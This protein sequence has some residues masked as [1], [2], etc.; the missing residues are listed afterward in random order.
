MNEHH[1]EY[2]FATFLGTTTAP[3]W[4]T[5][6]KKVT[7]AVA[8]LWNL[9]QAI[10]FEDGTEEAF[11][12]ALIDTT[13]RFKI[14]KSMLYFLLGIASTNPHDPFGAVRAYLNKSDPQLSL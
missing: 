13:I 6:K 9:R 4:W 3:F 5:H 10:Y 14:K 7:T 12:D 8:H 2:Y 11:E 1:L